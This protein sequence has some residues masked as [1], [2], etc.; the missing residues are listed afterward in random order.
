L[1]KTVRFTTDFIQN[2]KLEKCKAVETHVTERRLLAM[3]REL[4]CEVAEQQFR[5][6][7]KLSIWREKNM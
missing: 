3:S 5:N 1:E 2:V 7:L 4:T 6:I